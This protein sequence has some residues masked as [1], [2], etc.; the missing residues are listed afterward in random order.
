[1]TDEVTLHSVNGMKKPN[2]RLLI[3]SYGVLSSPNHS[4]IGFLVAVSWVLLSPILSVSR[5]IGCGEVL[6]TGFSAL[7]NISLADK[8]I[9]SHLS[10]DLLDEDVFFLS[11][12]HLAFVRRCRSEPS[13]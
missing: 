1:M 5:G 13:L 12:F 10:V 2:R 7:P 4:L 3:L 8:N 11:C 6:S 9:A